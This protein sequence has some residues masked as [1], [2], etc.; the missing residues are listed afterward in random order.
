MTE[1]PKSRMFRLAAMLMRTK[2][3]LGSSCAYV[4][5][6]LTF[7][8]ILAVSEKNTPVQ[9]QITSTFNDG[10]V[11]DPQQPAVE[12]G[13]FTGAQQAA[14]Q[15]AVNYW[16]QIL[17]YTITAE[18]TFF[19]DPT[20]PGG[21]AA[22]S[23]GWNIYLLDNDDWITAQ[24]T[25]IQNGI[26]DAGS[27]NLE[28]I[29]VH[30]L[31]HSL[32][33]RSTGWTLNQEGEGA[34]APYISVTFD[35][36]IPGT[37]NIGGQER[38][39]WASFLLANGAPVAAGQT[40]DLNSTYF[41][42]GG[43]NASAV[44]GDG[45]SIAVPVYSAPTGPGSTLVH[46]QTPFGNMNW[47][48]E[49][50][51]R[52][53]FAEVELAIMQDL[54]H[55]IDI[56]NF[57]G[58]S[59]YQSG[60]SFLP[61][62]IENDNGFFN[63][64]L[65]LDLETWEFYYEYDTGPNYGIFGIGLHIVGDYNSVIQNADL[66]AAGYAGTGI[67]VEGI[68]NTVQISEGVTVTGNGFEGTGVL[69]THG[70]G[71][72]VINYG[73]IEA[74]GYNNGRGIWLNADTAA[75]EN[76]GI[77][78]ADYFG[79]L[80]DAIYISDD[81][82]VG[83]INI[84][85]GSHITGHINSDSLF[86]TALNF[87]GG[88][89]GSDVTLEGD[90][91]LPGSTITVGA[92]NEPSRLILQG[93]RSATGNV[94][95]TQYGTLAPRSLIPGGFTTLS[96][97]GALTMDAGSTL[98]INLGNNSL[99][100]RIAVTGN[101]VVAA[102]SNIDLMSVF[103]GSY[104]LITGTTGITYTNES[105]NVLINGVDIDY[106]PEGRKIVESYSTTVVGG[107][108]LQLDINIVN[109]SGP[110]LGNFRLTWTNAELNNS[111]DTVSEN[112]RD[113][114]MFSVWFQDGDA[115][116]FDL[117]GVHIID[118]QEPRTVAD[119]TVSGDGY[120]MFN[121]NIIGD[122]SDTV[123]SLRNVTG[124][125]TMDGTG[126]MFLNGNNVFSGDVNL[127]SGITNVDSGW[128]LTSG[129][130]VNIGGTDALLD[131]FAIL[132]GGGTITANTVHV[133]STGVLAPG[134]D[135]DEF[136]PS[137]GTMTIVGNLAMDDDSWLLVDIGIDENGNNLSNRID[138]TGTA[139]VGAVN[140][141]LSNIIA[142]N[143][144]LLGD[145]IILTST[146]LTY[147]D[148]SAFI[149]VDGWIVPTDLERWTNIGATTQ[150]TEDNA[151]LL[152]VVGEI[153]N[154]WLDWTGEENNNQWDLTSAN[155]F[156]L[157]DDFPPTILNHFIPGDAVRFGDFYYLYDDIFF[158]EIVEL[159]VFD[160]T[161][162]ISGT[163]AVVGDMLVHGASNWTFT[164]GA[165]Y[166]DPDQST[167]ADATGSLVMQGTGTLLLL[168]DAEFKGRA[169]IQSGTLQ[170]GDGGFLGSFVGDIH[171]NSRVIFDNSE[172][173]YFDNNIS[174][175]GSL[176][177]RNAGTHR[178][179]GTLTLAGNN[180][181]TGLTVI[182]EGTLF[183]GEQENSIGG[184]AILSGA[185]L[186]GTGP[187]TSITAAG[188][189][190]N[191]G[192]YI[193]EIAGT[194]TA[195]RISNI[196]GVIYAVGA[197]HVEG[198]VGG[199][200]WDVITRPDGTVE[201]VWHIYD[202]EEGEW[203]GDLV[204]DEVNG[205]YWDLDFVVHPDG[206]YSYI[207]TG[208]PEGIYGPYSIEL[209]PAPFE[210]IRGDLFN[211]ANA[212]IGYV[213][214]ITAQNVIN[215]GDME[216]IGNVT[217]YNKFINDGYFGEFNV[218]TADTVENAGI[219]VG[220]TDESGN[221]VSEIHAA[222]MLKNESG[223][224][225]GNIR[226]LTAKDAHNRGGAIGYVD[227]MI[228]ENQ[229]I[230]ATAGGLQGAIYNIGVLQ[231]DSVY[232]EGAMQ[233]IG[234]MSVTN[235]LDNRGWIGSVGTLTAGSLDNRGYLVDVGTLTTKNGIVN[236]GYI[237]NVKSIDTQGFINQNGA[238]LGGTTQLKLNGGTF[239]NQEGIIIVG[240]TGINASGDWVF[241]GI[242]KMEIDG[243]FISTAGLFVIGVNDISTKTQRNS[244]IDVSGTAIIDGGH[245]SIFVERD[246]HYVAT[247]SDYKYVF[248][249]AKGGLEV[250]NELF[251]G[252]VDDPLL[253]PVGRYNDNQYWFIL[254]RQFL[255]SGEGKTMNERALGRYLDDVGIY[256][257][258]DYR[259]VLMALDRTRAA[260]SEYAGFSTFAVGSATTFT[261]D[262]VHKALDQMGGSIYGTM[263]T[264]S[265]QN[266]VMFHAAL[267]NVLRRDYNDVGG[268][269]DQIYRGQKPALN[270]HNRGIYNP[271]N[272]LWGMLYG[273]AGTMHSDGNDGKY[274]QGFFGM[275]AGFD[276]INERR[277]RMGLFLSM[278]E[279]SLY[280]SVQD[281]TLTKEFLAG[282]YFRKDR[283]NSYLLIQA[284]LGSNRYDTKRQI[285]FGGFDPISEEYAIVDRTA[286]NKHNAFLATA[287][288]ET[289]LRYRGGI[290]NLSPFVGA[291]YTGLVRE[292]FTERGADSLNLTTKSEDYHSFRTMFGMRFD[293]EAFRFRRGLASIYGNVAWMYEFEDSKRHTKFTARF[294]DVGLLSGTPSFTVYGNDPG[295]DWVQ[296]GFGV[297]YDIHA[298]LRVGL[299]YDAYANN[300]QVMHAGNLLFV[301]EL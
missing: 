46:P 161:I 290:L 142:D 147:E 203:T 197:I 189:I 217:V 140:I 15:R 146:G 292:G 35:D 8:L 93:T 112:W 244:V 66:L 201:Y 60:Y 159:G 27:L 213:G 165:I 141:N 57:F 42:F 271:T 299:G 296:A 265:F 40:Y 100:D 115:V 90:I 122:N 279:G 223:G 82:S 144:P 135:P 116:T 52:P 183:F 268:V 43:E 17:N 206:T 86:T 25:Q 218:L 30:E 87:G 178:G 136:G 6:L 63:R 199:G 29:I 274:T 109:N 128:S 250:R 291:Q 50:T 3:K 300:R 65:M 179:G 208:N 247:D 1:T 246:Q 107:N 298:H 287:H 103:G 167:L 114:H 157:A 207:F 243:N 137:F 241:N 184:I 237:T 36:P 92:G 81:V 38:N 233:T 297:K 162:N 170:I 49:T 124:G 180:T 108:A 257:S 41:S 58:R 153:G 215:Y 198:T 204:Y 73:I 262:P 210:T 120:W 59:I 85:G 139:D 72:T 284:G 28:H 54:G 240:D 105:A 226:E 171:N 212:Y 31:A 259:N 156:G 14:V 13:T 91:F 205:T 272:N 263:T 149:W 191:D 131:P 118:I 125:L 276:R 281:R 34:G 145:Y 18:A 37:Q 269:Y 22:G 61:R 285:S 150:K 187:A 242:E 16:N 158:P 89:L 264:A 78:F 225:I 12:Y 47:Q 96:I 62:E 110:D 95:V 134:D 152:S 5:A 53:F 188:I 98:E 288:I 286:K 143:A 229:L 104:T 220:T 256:P 7:A 88:G 166:G 44:W 248:I 234:K 251:L 138:V 221:F 154:F 160:R 252:S 39:T 174:G 83:V 101:A 23:T 99:S 164:G 219:I 282:H 224:Q 249:D 51:A 181:Y 293:T 33:I 176:I 283:P 130:T 102:G 129:G 132:A 245:V 214:S 254:E 21:A 70:S 195:A 173:V 4:L 289:G 106:I 9:A 45:V 295:R 74:T 200:E 68:G 230:N 117:A 258:G 32:G 75:V 55:E 24:N 211:S 175:S 11:I 192:G 232:N 236:T 71:A 216:K 155:W 163:T 80:N 76:Y 26:I 123:T 277:L 2:N 69:V 185:T 202:N 20:L 10:G 275:M 113:E 133:R 190:N 209:Q 19:R 84:Y 273:N 280:G 227:T 48:Y 148:N 239:N 56:R 121:G 260:S 255:Y 151:L 177:K 67:R 222:N 182:E 126:G 267:T 119:M 253:K 196:E 294:S 238:M 168:V 301:W 172:D 270:T 193:Y 266:T 169:W 278:G 97:T 194:L 79:F 186:S 231:A 235:E 228:V 94:Q 127:N 261:E 64:V 111:W 77:I